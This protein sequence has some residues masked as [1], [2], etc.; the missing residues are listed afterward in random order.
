PARHLETQTGEPEAEKGCE[1]RDRHR[2]PEYPEPR[3]DRLPAHHILAGGGKHDDDEEE[4][5]RDAVQDG[6]EEKGVDRFHACEG[7]EEAD[8]GRERDD[9]VERPRPAPIFI[10]TLPPSERF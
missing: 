7:D 2:P 9:A 10:E 6:R 1:H 5:R 8:E 3:A 4:W